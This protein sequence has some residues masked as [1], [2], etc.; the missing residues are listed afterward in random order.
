MHSGRQMTQKTAQG[1]AEVARSGFGAC[2][3]APS[4]RTRGANFAQS[5]RRKFDRCVSVFFAIWGGI[6]CI[7]GCAKGKCVKINLS[8]GAEGVKK[9]GTRFI[10]G[11]AEVRA[12][13]PRCR[14]SLSRAG[15]RNLV[16]GACAAGCTGAMRSA[17]APG[18]PL[19]WARVSRAADG[20][21]ATA[22]GSMYGA[23]MRLTHSA[24]V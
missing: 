1:H 13:E 4:E 7:S 5:P 24:K 10:P 12:S 2:W 16:P 14:C 11:S 15:R 3:D 19:R 9:V 8:G 20:L 17:S 6:E 21:R 22:S 18:P 23:W